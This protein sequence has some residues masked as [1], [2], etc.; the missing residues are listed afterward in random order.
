MKIIR[1]FYIICSVDDNWCTNNN[2]Y[3]SYS[4]LKLKSRIYDEAIITILIMIH[5]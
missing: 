5:I 1:T 4:T 2:R 3:S